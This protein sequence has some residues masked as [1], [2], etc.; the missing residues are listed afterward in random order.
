M[1]RPAAGA[2]VGRAL[3]LLGLAAVVPAV[4]AANLWALLAAVGGFL[5]AT[6]LALA[7]LV[8]VWLADQP[9]TRPSDFEHSLDLLRRAHGARAGWLVGLPEGDLESPGADDLSRDVRRRGAALVQLASVDGRAHVAREA[10]GTFVAVGDFPFGAGLLVPQD[11]DSARPVDA[12]ADEL[13]RLVAAMRLSQ[14]HE[15]GEQPGQL[16][17]K[18]LAAIAAGSQ[19]LEGIAKAGV[20]LAQQLAQRGA[21]IVL[22]GVGPAGGG[23]R[24][25]AVSSGVDARLEHLTVPGDA[26]VMRAVQ[27][28]VPI[29]THG[30]EDMFG[31]AIPDRRR[32]ERAG[33]AYPLRDGH[34]VIGA[35]VVTGAP[36]PAATPVADLV[37]RLVTELG[38]RLA[39]ARAVHVAEQRAVRDPLTGLSNRREFDRQ[40][41]LVGGKAPASVTLV[42]VDIDHFKRLN[43][44]LGHQAGD[45]ALRHVA[46]ILRQTVRD[47]DVVARIGGE[48]FAIWMPHTPIEVG[49]EVAERV[50]RTMETTL[51]RWD[52][53]THA[54]RVS[55]GVASYPGTVKD[56]ANL[57][58]AADAALYRAKEAGRNRVEKATAAG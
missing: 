49:V 17:A 38:S 20:E 28:G 43:D 15:E 32:S 45:S 53:T 4:Q 51:W 19:T 57:K 30:G 55:C 56:V 46:D 40:F 39:A 27:S 33:T 24:V 48:E 14:L 21:A 29:A 13:R 8:R 36:I 37:Q 31:S 58:G 52:G 11:P 44:T 22:Q 5:A 2:W 34:Y 10:E 35:V 42:F 1:K 6:G 25:V 3:A 26:P 54:L 9:I 12:V 7:P 16:V 47:N 50:R 18:R 23:A 41:A